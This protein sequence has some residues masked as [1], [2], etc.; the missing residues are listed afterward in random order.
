LSGDF[1]LEAL[2]LLPAKPLDGDSQSAKKA[3]SERLSNEVAQA[4]AGELRRRWLTETRPAPPGVLD[5]SGAERRMS[6]GIG[7]K[8]VDVT[9]ATDVDL[10]ARRNP[11]FYE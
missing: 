5:L 9:W 6:G 3:Y 10:V 4:F 7:A 1:L 11:D 2:K 8:K